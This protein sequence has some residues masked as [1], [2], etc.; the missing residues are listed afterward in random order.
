MENV[1]LSLYLNN[2]C[3][4]NCSYC[5]IDH[6]EE[7]TVN[8]EQVKK[9][10]LTNKDEIDFKN[11]SLYGGEPTIIC[12]NQ[13]ITFLKEN[14]KNITITTNLKDKKAI[15]NLINILGKQASL[16]VSYNIEIDNIL[17]TNIEI[18][19]DYINKFNIT[20]TKKNLPKLYDMI[21]FLSK[22]ETKILLSPEI[23]KN[24]KGYELDKE[25][26]KKQLQLIFDNKLERKL[27]NFDRIRKNIKTNFEQ[28][29]KTALSISKNGN[30]S[31]CSYV[32]DNY[33]SAHTYTFGNLTTKL[34]DINVEYP[35]IELKSFDNTNCMECK[36]CHN[37]HC[38]SR[39]MVNEDNKVQQQI[40]E[41]YSVLHDFA[42]TYKFKPNLEKINIFMTEQCNMKC[43]YCFEK[44]FKNRLGKV[45]NEI[46]EKS[47]DL[48]FSNDD[49]KEKKFTFFGGEPS[50]NI[51][52]MRH[53]LNYYLKLKNKGLKSTIFFDI[54]TNLLV[55]TDE[56]I[57]LFKEIRTHTPFYISV[58]CDGF[59]EL[60]DKQRIDLN[61]NGTY[62][63]VISNVKKLRMVLNKKCKCDRVI[64]CKHTVL[65][66]QNI[67]FIEKICN[68]AW[69]QRNLFD[70]F[71]MNYV[72]PG[73]GEHEFI[74]KENLQFIYDYYYKELPKINNNEKKEFITKY[75]TS[76]FY[77]NTNILNNYG[78]A[79]CD[80]GN[81]N[82]SIRSNGDIMLCHAFLDK[83]DEDYSKIKI[84]NI[85]NINTKDFGFTLD[86]PWYKMLNKNEN[87]NS[88]DLI[89]KSEL[90]YDCKLC[91]FKFMCHTCIANLKE[92]KGN[93]L[94]K[95][96]EQCM[97]TLN[98]AEI[99]LKIKEIQGLKELKELQE[100]ENEL[101]EH[102][103]E[104]ITDVGELAVGNRKILME[105][106]KNE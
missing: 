44:E 32:S 78:F 28:C 93:E 38:T 7:V 98:Q 74:T 46:I 23:D 24:L 6:N 43:T 106:I 72:T 95:T 87:I 103:R 96:K 86:N 73:K 36:K 70:E 47:M 99:L 1:S 15:E 26:L 57:E 21:S 3:N 17:K 85:L 80:A 102:I 58:S 27:L 68:E 45:S 77:L 81:N 97:R 34:K 79:V 37:Y 90:G 2:T 62:D 69:E 29:K 65:N 49:G 25:E 60:N 31:S 83:I 9:F 12:S 88:G 67:P 55:L 22:Y 50:L 53:A 35:N 18:F 10:I 13:F 64:I 19:K 14:F 4:L 101:I 84:D 66:N 54:N 75:L 61:G 20:V 89:V 94:I 51:E 39:Y 63:R 91:M 41:F 40:C 33:I 11:I 52:G 82:L 104:G 48:L 30:L 71:S 100:I 16:T 42:H 76:S 59:K 5:N 92:I 8:E 105:L 56:L